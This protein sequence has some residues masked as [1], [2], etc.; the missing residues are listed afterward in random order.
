[1]GKVVMSF[2]FSLTLF[3]VNAQN[4]LQNISSLA[5]GA[6]IPMAEYKMED[7]SGE[8]VSL[9]SVQKKNGLLV[10]F[11]C[12]TCPFVL[13]WQDR[14][15]P[16]GDWTLENNVGFVLVNSNEAQ[17]KDVDALEKMREHAANNKYNTFYVVDENSQLADAFGATR[18]PEVFLFDKNG[19]LVYKGAIDDNSEDADAVKKPYLGVALQNLLTETP[20]DPNA[21]KSIGCTIKRLK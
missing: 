5:I 10:I 16:I 9:N 12:N 19:I 18:T 14:Y 7:V 21:T 20:N 15:I 8:I 11:S 2:L 17:R 4:N 6:E 13:G 1:M 3:V